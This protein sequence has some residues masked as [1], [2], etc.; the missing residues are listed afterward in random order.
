LED[1]IDNVKR[2]TENL[3]DASEEE[4]QEVNAEKIKYM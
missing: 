2:N 4:D 3:I 1:N